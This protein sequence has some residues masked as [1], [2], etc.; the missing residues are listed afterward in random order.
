MNYQAMEYFK[1]AAEE[2]SFTAGARK[3]HIT[4]QTLSAGIAHVEEELGCRLFE[5]TTP[6]TLTNEGKIF[7]G[8]AEEFLSKHRIMMKHFREISAGRSGTLH[9]GV[10]YTRGRSVMPSL[11]KDFLEEYPEFQVVL[12]ENATEELI[13]ELKEG[14][15]DLL[16]ARIAGQDPDLNLHPFYREHIVL[17]ASKELLK[18]VF[19]DEWSDVV[20]QAKKGDFTRFQ[21][22]PFV[23][24]FPED[25]TGII[26]EYFLKSHNLQPKVR[27]ISD[28]LET[29]LAMCVQGTGAAFCPQNLMEVSVPK[30]A[31]KDLVV[32]SLPKE[33]SYPIQIATRRQNYS[34]RAVEAFIRMARG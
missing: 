6:L 19:K 30:E 5:R 32:F 8:Y 15:I 3:L 7:Q 28:N 20:A 26:A 27:A 16:V 2:G 31:R 34:R 25:T 13:K 17:S 1:A 14:E 24:S 33:A 12:H 4:Q 11:I 18:K 23:M 10:G 9:V 29:L 21:E 22:C